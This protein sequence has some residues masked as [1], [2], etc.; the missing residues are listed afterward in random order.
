MRLTSLLTYLLTYGQ[1]IL[2]YIGVARI[3]SGDS[4]Y[5]WKS[6]RPFFTRRFQKTLH[7]FLKKLATFLVVPSKTRSKTTT[8]SSK[9][10]WHGK[11]ISSCS[12]WGCT[13]KLSLC[14]T[15]KFFFS[16]GGAGAPAALPGYAY[17]SLVHHESALT[18]LCQYFLLIGHEVHLCEL[19]RCELKLHKSL[20][21]PIPVLI[22]LAL[23]SLKI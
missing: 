22:H 14:I 18:D 8:L 7:F 3:L 15:L 9:S 4:L 6:W 12:A 5:F 21:F 10:S 13:Y 1:C 16:P 17:A 19:P 11:K 20:L 2:L 23:P